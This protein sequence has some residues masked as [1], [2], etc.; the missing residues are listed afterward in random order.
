MIQHIFWDMIYIHYQCFL[1]IILEITWIRLNYI[2]LDA[3]MEEYP[4]KYWQ[5]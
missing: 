1:K 4:L 5:N 3:K 2:Y